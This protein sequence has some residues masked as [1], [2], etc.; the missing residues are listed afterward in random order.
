[1]DVRVRSWSPAAGPFVGYLIAHMEALSIADHL[2][3]REGGQI[4]YRPTVHYAYRPC[5]D[6]VL[7]VHEL[8]GRALE[9]QP[10]QRIL[11]AEIVDGQDELGVLLAGH[12]RGAYWL[13]SQLSIDEAR[14]ILPHSNAT[15][16]QVAAGI[17][18]G[19]AAAIA[20]PAEGLVEPEELD[21]RLVLATARPYLGRLLG[22]WSDWTPLTG[23]G[24]L[25][26]EAL[27]LTDPWR[28]ANVR[29]A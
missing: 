16:L 1:V 6:S 22:V 3:L 24:R 13:G 18:G 28:F 23:R 8:V 21:F 5:P 11:A 4:V 10:W 2:T 26:P 14:A 9:P 20:R 27:D 25:F 19:L 17:L 15:A 7:S 12:P 29:V